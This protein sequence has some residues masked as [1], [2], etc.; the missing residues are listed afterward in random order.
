MSEELS[1][2]VTVV[3]ER[4]FKLIAEHEGVNLLQFPVHFTGTE[5]NLMEMVRV[6]NLTVGGK[7]GS[8][9]QMYFIEV[10]S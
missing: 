6:W 9:F 1:A 10:E 2:C 8:G 7:L 4:R 5:T 3:K